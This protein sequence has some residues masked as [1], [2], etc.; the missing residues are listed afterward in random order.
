M[1][2]VPRPASHRLIW[3][4]AA[5][6]ALVTAV[7]ILNILAPQRGGPLALSQIFAPHLLIP[8]LALLPLSLGVRSRGLLVGII[9]AV[10][11]GVVRFGPGL[12]SIPAAPSEPGATSVQILSW[13]LQGAASATEDLMAT[14]RASDAD[15]VALQELSRELAATMQADPGLKARYGYAALEPRGGAGGLGVL[16]RFPIVAASS[17]R[18]PAVQE[19]ELQ[20][21]D[22]RLT[23]INAHPF[24]PDL[25]IRPPVPFPIDYDPGLRDTHLLQIRESIDQAIAEGRR[26]IVL[27]DF[28]VTDREPGFDDLSRGL[29]DA[30]EEVGQG[31]GSTWRPH[32]IEFV[33]FGV[34]R[35][36]YVL[37]GPGTRPLSIAED[38]EPGLSD[39]CRL[40]ASA[41]VS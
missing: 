28:N 17:Q 30:H 20:L 2:P 33:P 1:M 27:G 8:V 36:D 3:L 9:L 35:I 18:D 25:P 22:R 38:C 32:D 12:V 37:G 14:L 19:V 15:V 24:A 39:H 6:P 31:T 29:W 7:S 34:L 23:I 16:S 21:L 10:A 40:T 26:L 11:I 5:Y 41:A 13:N 4:L